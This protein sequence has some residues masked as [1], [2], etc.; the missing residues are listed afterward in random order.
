MNNNNLGN[1]PN[2]VVYN[3]KYGYIS[4]KKL[5]MKL[6]RKDLSTTHLCV[7]A[8]LVL[9]LGVSFLLSMFLSIAAPEMLITTGIPPYLYYMINMFGSAFTIGM[10]FAV[11]LAFK[12]ESVSNY[13]KFQR[14]RAFD[15]ILLILGAVAL[16]LLA[17]FPSM[18][19]ME[20]VESVGLDGGAQESLAGTNLFESILYILTIAVFPPIFE[21]FAFRGVLLSSL[22]KHGDGIALVASSVA[23]A[24]MHTSIS[25]MPFALICGF[26]M[27]YVYLKTNNLWL[28]IAIHFVNNAN[29]T[30]PGILYLYL[31]EATV[32]LISNLI[33]Y[34][35]ILI[36]VVALIILFATKKVFYTPENERRSISYELSA[37]SKTLAYITSPGIIAVMILTIGM[38]VFSM[39]GMY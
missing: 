3:E 16:W 15:S 28:S 24:L 30:L 32:N 38:I 27:G 17:N 20:L 34:G 5:K 19:I 10:P 22:R 21:E 25:S 9:S 1:M 2:D 31:P 7:I 33:F 39:L 37:G 11:Y 8:A 14:V 4:L 18:L 6:I 23:F 26:A 29:A 35:L 36:G 12:G 13:L